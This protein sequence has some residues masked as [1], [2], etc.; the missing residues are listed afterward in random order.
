MTWNTV[1]A[2]VAAVTG[3]SLVGTVGA[4][5]GTLATA[6]PVAPAAV[7]RIG[8]IDERFQ[9]YNVEMVEVIGGRFWKPYAAGTA[10]AQPRPA[11][12]G[13]V[14]EKSPVGLSPDLFQQR[15]PIDLSNARLRTLA[16]ALGPAYMRVS[17]TWANSIYFH[18]GD[19]PPPTTAPRGFQS[20]LTRDAWSGVIQFAHAVNAK[21]VSSF[22]ISEGT[23]DAS[24]A[25]TTGQAARWLAYTK[26]AGGAIAVAEFFNEPTFAAIGGAPRGYDAAAFARDF[27]VFQKF[28]RA[29]AP[30]MLI[31]GPGSVGEGV[32]L[33]SGM[34]GMLK[35]PDLLAAD[36][37]PAFDIFS[38]HFYGAV[39]MRCAAPGGPMAGTTPDAALSDDWLSRTGTVYAYY[40]GLRDRF[41]PGTSIWLTETADAACGGNPWGATFLDTFRYVDQ[42][43]QLATRG[44]KTVF[45]NTLAA[46]E[47]GL[48]DEHTLT[49]RPN[50]WAAVLWHRLMGATV[51]DA[52]GPRPG[53]RLYAHCL[54]GQTGGVTLLAV[55]TSR[56]SANSIDL[57]AAADRYS[58]TAANADFTQV[59]LNGEELALQ[60]SG[61][62]PRLG[63]SRIPA[64]RVEFAPASITFLAMAGAGNTN[65]Q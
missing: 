62:L 28:A 19:D 11:P 54:P 9:S 49:P 29:A 51:L 6:L 65:C 56:T 59:R 21:V 39:S 35:T 45:H 52:G 24:G 27:A 14:D 31:A 3:V 41:S 61:A 42:L 1:L 36:P 30:T 16:A 44:V 43:G 38:Y 7:K 64:G 53:L 8:T 20:V 2:A 48:I 55:N 15:P 37:R 17:G 26:S 60:P 5:R 50:Y 32:S 4:S 63:G 58:L 46:S 47:Y 33:G 34:P 10:G 13:A 22:A 18:D 40:A 12:P 57:S 23:R 25:W